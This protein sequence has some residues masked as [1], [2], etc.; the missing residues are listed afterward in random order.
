[1]L[2]RRSTV[3][4]VAAALLT[5]AV[6]LSSCSYKTDQ[7][8]TIG[9]GTNDR[10]AS[11]DVL[12]MRVVAFPDGAGRLIG[13]FVFNDN[14]AT[15]PATLDSVEG[16]GI[17]AEVGR[18]E[19]AANESVNLADDAQVDPVS[20]TG[21]FV[22]GDLVDLIFTFSTNESVSLEVPVVKPCGQYVD[23]TAPEGSTPTE[24]AAAEP[25]EGEDAEADQSFVCDHPTET[26][27][28]AGH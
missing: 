20:I 7:V 22:P 13:T 21:D 28:E 19:V 24:E 10:D 8:N 12:G 15:E 5:G 17:T 16:E 11:V 27:E 6:L 4:A 26:V 18:V 25:T 14:D 2:H 9:A 1:M 3:T 23:I